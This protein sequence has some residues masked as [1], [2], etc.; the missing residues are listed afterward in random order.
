MDIIH[1]AGPRF[2]GILFNWGLLGVLTT[3][4]YIYYLNFPRDTRLNKALGTDVSD[5]SSKEFTDQDCA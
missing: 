3:Q 2:I 4:V 5:F 1:S